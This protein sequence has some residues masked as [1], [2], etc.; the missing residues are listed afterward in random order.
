[1]SYNAKDWSDRALAIRNELAQAIANG[2][3]KSKIALIKL[4]EALKNQNKSVQLSPVLPQKGFT[5]SLDQ[6]PEQQAAPEKVMSSYQPY[7]KKDAPVK[8][9]E[10][11]VV[12]VAKTKEQTKLVDKAETETKPS[13]EAQNEA[14]G[15]V[16]NE[17]IQTQ[18]HNPSSLVGMSYKEIKDAFNL[19]QLREFATKLGVEFDEVS[20]PTQLAKKLENALK[21]K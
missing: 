20:T 6:Q 9:K 10:A 5:R 21:A 2:E 17:T 3:E 4:D 14:F 18:L 12:V 16:E 19:Q 8:K 13:D 15:G 7:A 11:T 1:M